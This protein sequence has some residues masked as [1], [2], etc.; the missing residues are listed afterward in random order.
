M[1][2]MSLCMIV[3]N[4]SS[5]LQN[6]L[7]S[8]KDIVDEI[9]IVDTGSTDNTVEIAKKY[10]DNIFFFKWID[11]FSA[12][13]N[14]SFSKAT[15]D[16]ILWLDADDVLLAED[17]KKLMILKN[18][19]DTSIDSV[20]MIY[21]YAFDEFG[22]VILSLR[23]NRLVKRKLQFKWYG[24]VHE[25]LAVDGNIFNSDIA[26]SHKRIHV[27][28]GR[29]LSIFQ[30][31]LKKGDVFS[32]RDRYYYANE[33][34]DNGFYEKAIENYSLFLDLK[35]GWIEDKISTCHKI[36]DIYSH[37]GNP[38]K[39]LQYIWKSFELSTPRAEFCCKL[40]YYFLNKSDT[41][42]ALFWYKLA[43]EL[44]KPE[45]ISGFFLD[46]CWTWLP[47]IQLCVCYSRLGDYKK[48]YEHNEVARSFRPSDAMILHNKSL[49]EGILKNDR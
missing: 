26:V 9:I 21:N 25:Y 39:E 42:T 49:L 14:Y 46:S 30:K 44:K 24:P 10:T 29:N 3:K 27:K 36:S 48:S 11:D 35:E 12:A 34:L 6:C 22:N 8:I 45:G 2:S 28:S 38:E 23:R 20:T 13:R 41:K 4:E 18:S 1:I 5:V 19:L 40:G 31:R 37:L 32:P 16:Y 7:D 47:H 15:K 33:L 17:Q 43:S